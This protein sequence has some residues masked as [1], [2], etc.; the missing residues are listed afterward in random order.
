MNFSISQVFCKK[1]LTFYVQYATISDNII[2]I[3]RNLY[4]VAF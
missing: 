2:N 4:L 3:L 1:V